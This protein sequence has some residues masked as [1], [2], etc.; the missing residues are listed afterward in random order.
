MNAWRPALE[1]L[2]DL[3]LYAAEVFPG[4]QNIYG[5]FAPA[6]RVIA[7]DN[8]YP[9]PEDESEEKQLDLSELAANTRS[10]RSYLMKWGG[11]DSKGLDADEAD[12]EIQQIVQE[13]RMLEDSFQAEEPPEVD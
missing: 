12:A 10:I 1:W 2:A 11:A 3:V 9:I 4:L 8:Q 6:P 13:R 7:V 5:E